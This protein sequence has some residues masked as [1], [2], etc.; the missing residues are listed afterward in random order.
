MTVRAVV[1]CTGCLRIVVVGAVGGGT[2]GVTVHEAV[3]AGSSVPPAV[4]ART[5]KTK[6]PGSSP[7]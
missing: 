1:L 4:V 3:T 5:A 7:L 6:P 2:T